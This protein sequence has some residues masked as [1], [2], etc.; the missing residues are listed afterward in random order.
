MLSWGRS[1]GPP[2]QMSNTAAEITDV[3]Q[4]RRRAG[5]GLQIQRGFGNA[6][7]PNAPH[8]TG[9][10]YLKLGTGATPVLRVKT[11]AQHLPPPA[12]GRT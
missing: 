11:P 6:C 8:Q 2:S 3:G 5:L 7:L 12:T 1:I 4:G 9:K 10:R